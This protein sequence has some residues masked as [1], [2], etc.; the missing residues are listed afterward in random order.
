MNKVASYEVMESYCILKS[1]CEQINVK[2]LFKTFHEIYVPQ[3]FP[4]IQYVDI[5]DLFMIFR[6]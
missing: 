3:K 1:Y 5:D 2:I 6:C 4:P